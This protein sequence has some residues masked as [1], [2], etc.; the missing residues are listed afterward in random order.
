MKLI[1]KVLSFNINLLVLR[2]LN[3]YVCIVIGCKFDLLYSV[4]KHKY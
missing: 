4:F 1:K 2:N 3:A